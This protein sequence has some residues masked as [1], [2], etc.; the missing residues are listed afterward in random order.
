[1]LRGPSTFEPT[2]WDLL[3]STV[4]LLHCHHNGTEVPC[5]SCVSSPFGQLSTLHERTV[6]YILRTGGVSV[7]Y[8]PEL[9]H[10]G[11]SAR[12]LGAIHHV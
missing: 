5:D 8:D 12:P 11:E 3:T 10:D 6:L 7:T 2:D 1:M 9:L 4:G